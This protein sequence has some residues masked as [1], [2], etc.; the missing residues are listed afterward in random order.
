ME[1]MKKKKSKLGE[2]LSGLA[3]PFFMGIIL[4]LSAAGLN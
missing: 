2:Y 4:F 3:F 1:K